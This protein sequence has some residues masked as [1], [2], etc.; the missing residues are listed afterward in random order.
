M[1]LWNN[2]PEASFTNSPL[3][4]WPQLLANHTPAPDLL[5]LPELVLFSL[6][7]SSLVSDKNI[8][9]CTRCKGTFPHRQASAVIPRPGLRDREHTG[10]QDARL[11]RHA[12]QLTH[13][14]R[15]VPETA[16]SNA[17]LSGFPRTHVP[18]EWLTEDGR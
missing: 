4:F 18:G 5:P 14:S 2:N 6:S 12:P 11:H 10:T 8:S 9:K 7:V 17:Y 15:V 16:V 13:K 1:I 3:D